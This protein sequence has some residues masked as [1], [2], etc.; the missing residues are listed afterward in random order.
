MAD[1][2]QI[3]AAQYDAEDSQTETTNIFDK[4][5]E[6][7]EY[8]SESDTK[9]PEDTVIEDSTLDG[10]GRR[11]DKV[12]H[13]KTYS[14][15]LISPPPSSYGFPKSND[16]NQST[17][18]MLLMENLQKQLGEKDQS[19]KRVQKKLNKKSNQYDQLKHENDALREELE[20]MKREMTVVKM[21]Q[22]EF[23]KKIQQLIES[24]KKA[25]QSQLETMKEL[26]EAHTSIIEMRESL[27][28]TDQ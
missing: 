28:N 15:S 1:A 21:N 26:K 17:D 8:R 20:D 4:D 7:T 18:F 25:N 19:L 3:L 27:K 24:K 11:M 22:Q 14:E 10:Y 2:L 16:V 12:I 13:E 9:E 23:I 6:D 5:I